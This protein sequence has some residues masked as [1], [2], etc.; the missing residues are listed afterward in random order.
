MCNEAFFSYKE[1]WNYVVCRKSDGTGD[2]RVKQ[3][4]SDLERHHIFLSRVE[5]R[6]FKK[7]RYENRRGTF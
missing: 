5:S 7:E 2:H 4:K 1:E 3:N 6:F